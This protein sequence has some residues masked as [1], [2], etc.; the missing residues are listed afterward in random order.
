MKGLKLKKEDTMKNGM[1]LFSVA[2]ATG[3]VGFSALAEGGIVTTNE[4]TASS[5]ED[6]VIAADEVLQVNCTSAVTLSGCI[7]GEGKIYKTGGKALTLGY[8]TNTFSGGIHASAGTLTSSAQNANT[9]VFGSGPIR[10][11]SGNGAQLNVTTRPRNPIEF[12][13]SS[14]TSKSGLY[15]GA[16]AYLYG[17]IVAHGDLYITDGYGSK[18]NDRNASKAVIGK[19]TTSLV[20]DPGY[21][22]AA[23]PNPTYQFECPITADL[24][25]GF[26]DDNSAQVS[27]EL[28]PT[29]GRVGAYLFNSTNTIGKVEIDQIRFR[30]NKA[31]ALKGTVVEF[32]GEHLCDDWGYLEFIGVDQDIAALITPN[33]VTAGC[34]ISNSTATAVTITLSGK[35]GLTADGVLRLCGA[36]NPIHVL[37][38]LPADFT[39]IFRDCAV[40]LESELTLNSGTIGFAGAATATGVSKVTLGREASISIGS[41]CTP[42]ADNPIVLSIALGTTIHLGNDLVVQKLLVDGAE[43]PAGEYTE[44]PLFTITGGGKLTVT[45]G[46]DPA[47][48]VMVAV[49]E[50]ETVTGVTISE[51]Q[52]LCKIGSGTLV[53]N[54]ANTYSGGTE[55]CG[56]VIEV[57]DKDAL[58]TGVVTVYGFG[59]RSGRLVFNLPAEET[60]ANDLVIETASSLESPALHF[61]SKTVLSGVVHAKADLYL[62]TAWGD[63]AGA[64]SQENVRFTGAVTVDEGACI[65]GAPHCIV[66]FEG[67]LTTPLLN[68]CYTAG[69][70]ASN[71]GNDGYFQLTE[72]ANNIQR[73]RL[74]QT[75]IRCN[76]ALTCTNAVLE[77]VDNGHLADDLGRFEFKGDQTVA[78]FITPVVAINGGGCVVTN[79]ETTTCWLKFN[80]S[81]ENRDCYARFDGAFNLRY[82]GLGG[83]KD[84]HVFTFLHRRHAMKGTLSNY[85]GK[86]FVFGE[87]TSMPKVTGISNSNSASFTVNSDEEDVLDGMTSVAI[88]STTYTFSEAA[89]RS[90][91]ADRNVQ[92]QR[93]TG[94]LVL[95]GTSPLQVKSYYNNES[96][97]KFYYPAGEY[98]AKASDTTFRFNYENT[99]KGGLTG[100]VLVWGS[101]ANGTRTGWTNM[102]WTGESAA[103]TDINDLANWAELPQYVSFKVPAAWVKFAAADK[104]EASLT[105]DVHWGGLTFT[106]ASTGFTLKSAANEPTIHLYD[107]GLSV[108]DSVANGEGRTFTIEPLVD[109]QNL[110]SPTFKVP[111]DDKLVLSGIISANF[112]ADEENAGTIVLGGTIPDT[113]TIP[114]GRLEIAEGA[115]LPEKFNA[116]WLG[117]GA[118]LDVKCT[119]GEIEVKSFRIGGESAVD[120]DYVY[121]NLIIRQRTGRVPTEPTHSATWT[122]GAG[123]DTSLTTVA[124]WDAVPLFN[125]GALL[126]F[127]A[128]GALATVSGE[129]MSHTLNFENLAEV[130]DEGPTAF[131]LRGATENPEENV[132]TVY[133]K[134]SVDQSKVPLTL[135]NMTLATPLHEDQ[136]TPGNNGVKTLTLTS[137]NYSAPFPL[138]LRNAIVEKPI[139]ATGPERRR[140]ITAESGT[141]E[142]KGAYT[143]TSSKWQDL[144]ISAGATL[145]LSGGVSC[146]WKTAIGGS[147]TLIITNKPWVSNQS[148]GQIQFGGDV[149]W[150]VPSNNVGGTGGNAGYQFASGTDADYLCNDVFTYPTELRFYAKSYA[151]A[152]HYLHSTTQRVGALTWTELAA[153]KTSA[154]D[155]YFTGEEGSMLW[156]D[157]SD[158]CSNAFSYVG[159]LAFRKSGEAECILHRTSYMRTNN[160]IVQHT[161]TGPLLIDGGQLTLDEGVQW[162]NGNIMIS[163][164]GVL[165]VSESGQIGKELTLGFEGTD[166]RIYIPEGVTVRIANAT[167]GGVPVDEGTYTA[168][169]PGLFGDHLTG[170]GS[171]RVGKAGMMFIVK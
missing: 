42:F 86:P 9:T 144:N 83:V 6:I 163:G 44:S 7:S 89:V 12:V 122:G 93:T 113:L 169:T 148:N 72:P 56:G 64:A 29:R 159:N 94:K 133:G 59:D 51:G 150:A 82:D 142:I 61:A 157:N 70:Q 28:C 34:Q 91:S 8:H 98:T 2:I 13:G 121:G 45:D 33:T 156:L 153:S 130:A 126:N 97:Q 32:T 18:P 5:S 123:E 137:Q 63:V 116:I 166:S 104:T 84:S 95:N 99:S 50:G 147:G 136:G 52:K 11:D 90:L 3:L 22:L 81:R 108:E 151:S 16:Q 160:Q 110:K 120:G 77:W 139:Y 68:C 73:I 140:T 102:V 152:R 100:T 14:S 79:I 158:I 125:A 4:I 146:Y 66:S 65:G 49:S 47:T 88:G 41:G 138:T 75:K 132:L 155:A 141:N 168:T 20:I 38:D 119:A 31:N 109:L 80:I 124:N 23:A 129:T 131:T 39:Q 76:A 54:A 43:C 69:G 170:E 115:T 26:W 107:N 25:K 15:I 128:A 96:S 17:D 103:S 40:P 37:P 60:I 74:D 35:A 55:I 48:L 111:A 101:N 1:R 171:L 19:A 114:A 57:Q 46:P 127:A 58:G 67:V 87:G 167:V 165:A 53:L 21:R 105:N 154:N 36:F 10:I 78:D 145:I 27:E 85:S 149:V 62:S 24:V 92:L 134:V 162:L 71:G 30:C 117:E 161:T 112:T 164:T 135:E 106:A 143:Y 118:Q